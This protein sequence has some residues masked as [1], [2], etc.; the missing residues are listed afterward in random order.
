[1]DLNNL[2][3]QLDSEFNV[4]KIKDDWSWMFD[5]RFKELSLKSFRKPNHH[6]GLV[7]KNSDQVL[8]IYTAFAPSTYVLKK[9]QKKG[10]KHV[11][12]VVKHPFD[13]DGRKTA[14]G[15][16][17]ISDKDYE[18]MS[19]M[20]ISLYSLH[21]PMD[22]N[23]NDKVVS[24]AYSFAKVIGLKVKD[25][26]AEDDPNPGLKLGLIGTVSDK[27]FDSMVKRL[28]SILGYKVKTMK[29]NDKIG[30]I[31]L[32]TGG[33]FIPE[34]VKEAKEKGC[35]TYITG[36]ITPNAS[37]YSRKNY[38]GE[39]EKIEKL[40]LNVIGCSHY[41]TEKWAMEYSILFFKQFCDAEFIED[42]FALKRLE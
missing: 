24:T 1:M 4:T 13:W 20:R 12:L 31:A 41:L 23:R 36:I 11:L 32:T 40:G 33:G 22:K 27:D 34:I 9:I 30:K 28:S 35:S 8:K 10:L 29:V 15:F 25:E 7:V 2:V 17:H 39:L 6:T 26:F 42:E 38:P 21:T 19:D 18:I 3:S 5:N 14:S 16:I 37:L